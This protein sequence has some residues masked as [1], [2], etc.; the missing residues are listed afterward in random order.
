MRKNEVGH[1][2]LSAEYCFLP[3]FGRF[4]ISVT[5][6]GKLAFVLCRTPQTSYC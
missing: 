4:E 2:Y 6:I 5:L 1:E 3:R